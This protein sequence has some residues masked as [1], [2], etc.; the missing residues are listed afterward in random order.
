[1]AIAV[2]HQSNGAPCQ[3]SSLTAN[4]Q[5]QLKNCYKNL[6]N[7][8]K[9][10]K[11]KSNTAAHNLKQTFSVNTNTACINIGT[12]QTIVQTGMNIT[13]TNKLTDLKTLKFHKAVLSKYNSV[14]KSNA[15]KVQNSPPLIKGVL[16]DIQAVVRMID[17]AIL[18]MQPTGACQVPNVPIPAASSA[19]HSLVCRTIDLDAFAR[20]ITIKYAQLY[21]AA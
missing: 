6:K 10:L 11:H 5:Q 17:L 12:I 1:M 15:L 7:Q 20:V 4:S 18:N 13:N 8:A 3:A 2:L 16:R 14:L 9:I 21:N 19:L